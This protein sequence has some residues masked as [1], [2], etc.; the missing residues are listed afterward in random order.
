MK[1]LIFTFLVILFA[2]G[3]IS[4]NW[5]KSFYTDDSQYFLKLY[6]NGLMQRLKVRKESCNQVK[7]FSI[8]FKN[9]PSTES[10]QF[11]L[12]SKADHKKW[13]TLY[14]V[15]LKDYCWYQVRVKGLNLNRPIANQYV[16]KI[17]PRQGNLSYYF[18]GYIDSIIPEMRITGSPIKQW[19]NLGRFGS[20]VV[21]GGGVFFKIWEPTASKVD[22]F[23][24]YSL[25]AI[26]LT[27]DSDSI[28]QKSH[29]IY[30]PQADDGDHYQYK[31]YKNGKYEN[32]Q[33]GNANNESEVKVD[34]MATLI[35][36][37]DKGGKNNGYINPSAVVELPTSFKWKYDPIIANL[38]SNEINNL[39]IYQLWALTFNPQ[40][41]RGQYI[42]G[43]YQD[44]ER[45]IDYLVDLGI[46]A[47]EFLPLNE[48]RFKASWGYALDSLL[49]LQKSFG[50][51]KSLKSLI[52]KL[53]AKKI[54]VLFDVVINHVNNSL[55]RDPLTSSISNSKFY[56]GN[57]GWGPAP[58]FENIMVQK[59]I[60]DSFLS[61]RRNFHIDGFRWDMIEYV[62]RDNAT[63]Y[64]FLQNLISLLKMEDA[65][66]HNSA[67]QLP[68]N[69]WVTYP[70]K[71]GGLGFDS[72]WNDKF[73]NFF[74]L[75][76]DH[77]RSNNRSINLFPLQAALIG[78]SD[79]RKT[80]GEYSFG[81]PLRTVNYLGSHDFVGNKDPILRLVS[82]YESFEWDA[83][84][85]F[86]TVRP[87]SENDNA[88]F[89]MIHNTFTHDLA[90]VA[91]GVLFTKPGAALFYQGEE[92]A[93]DLN[94][95][96]EWS[97]LAAT[98]NNAFPSKDVDMHRYISSHKMVWEYFNPQIKGPLSFL[99]AD[100]RNLFKGHHLFFKQMIRFKKEN[101]EINFEN[102][103]NVHLHYN[104]SVITY[105]IG[106]KGKNFLVVANFAHTLNDSWVYF[107]E[108][109]YKWWSEIINSSATIY[110]GE[111]NLGHNIISLL[112]GRNNNVR[113]KGPS[114]SIFANVKKAKITQDLFLKGTF[115][116]WAADKKYMLQKGSERGDVYTVN[117]SIPAAAEYEFKLATSDWNIELG[118]PLDGNNLNFRPNNTISGNLS[119]VPG[120][121]NGKVSLIKGQYKFL[122]DL[123]T[124]KYHFIYTSKK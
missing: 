73:K 58:H 24:N 70:K 84:N 109:K 53:H 12:M 101:P 66:F 30:L 104:N 55:I 31:F 18:Q 41:K 69:V 57:T 7:K 23:L 38:Q 97:Y 34:P 42:P 26:T 86:F 48:N 100:E 54:R 91:Y 124:F 94:I 71:D 21:N 20:T 37:D 25:A 117:I 11:K 16:I 96:N 95:E 2:Q 87:L 77:Y 93:N 123:K 83:F 4:A 49:L 6:S 90:R 39:I 9:N 118:A 13:P 106:T 51:K 120:L 80:G 112:A 99:N 92:L 17:T 72:Q 59:W 60:T 107:P 28:I 14:K 22:L 98:D 43:T 44:I 116:A 74:E 40:Q 79:H 50:P 63:S 65:D 82:G 15:N 119:Y 3:N 76:F 62:Y 68:D 32:L 56:K 8:L 78:T 114:I 108:R 105:E 36:Y 27:A 29:V 102:A 47:V 85:N 81:P 1:G 115:N 10:H 88:S 121:K 19:I 64:T 52:D 122:F 61:L 67:E 103:R 89:K 113:L 35:K 111:N 110:G 75:E 33:V 46:T 45:K 5:K